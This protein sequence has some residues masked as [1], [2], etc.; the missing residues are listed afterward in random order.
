[1]PKGTELIICGATEPVMSM[2]KLTRLDRVFTMKAT[3]DDAVSA[4][5]L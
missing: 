1:M 3:V 2:F 5:A 4:L